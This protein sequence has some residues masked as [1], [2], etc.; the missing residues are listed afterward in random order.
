MR[1]QG[2]KYTVLGEQRERNE[3]DE[4]R[5]SIKCSLS[6]VISLKLTQPQF[7]IASAR[8]NQ[9]KVM[10]A[11]EKQLEKAGGKFITGD[12]F[13]LADFVLTSQMQAK[14]LNLYIDKDNLL[15]NTHTPGISPCKRI[16]SS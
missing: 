2:A 9:K 10:K 5:Y 13:T 16:L 4:V 1:E 7:V 12:Q 14:I 11:L 3:K 8:V 6:K 15:T